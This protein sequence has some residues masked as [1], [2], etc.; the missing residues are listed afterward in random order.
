MER[1][2]VRGPIVAAAIAREQSLYGISAVEAAD[3]A[4]HDRRLYRIPGMGTVVNVH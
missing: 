4:V 3:R 2:L 1:H